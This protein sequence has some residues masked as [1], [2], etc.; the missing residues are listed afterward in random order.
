MRKAM[1]VLLPLAVFTLIGFAIQAEEPAATKWLDMTN[2]YF[3]Q[4]LPQSEGLMENLAWESLKIKNGI[5]QVVTYK[6]EWEEKYRAAWA[7]SQ[8]RR[9]EFDPAKQLYVCGLCQAWQQI[10]LDKVRWEDVKFSGGEISI[11]ESEDSAI[12]VQIHTIVEKTGAA[13]DEMKKAEEIQKE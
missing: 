9:K 4:P 12:V 1:F 13:M 11:G 8:K 6:P 7:E 3:C 2:C 5:V 10:P